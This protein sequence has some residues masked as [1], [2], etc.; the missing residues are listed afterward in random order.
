MPGF[1]E[2]LASFFDTE[3]VDKPT[4]PAAEAARRARELTQGAADEDYILTTQEQAEI[5]DGGWIPVH[6]SCILKL[7][8]ISIHAP[9]LIDT[10]GLADPL[11]R[12]TVVFKEGDGKEY[13]LNQP[14]PKSAFRE[15]LRSPS[16][17][18][19]WRYVIQPQFA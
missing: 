18:Q 11:G 4:V 13:E 2:A 17:G 12:C 6:S 14:M 16:K 3:A 1:F 5:A 19:H 8:W 15:W 10:L 7:R 9:R